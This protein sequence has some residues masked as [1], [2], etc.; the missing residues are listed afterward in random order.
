MKNA[1]TRRVFQNK[2]VIS[3]FANKIGNR[4]LSSF[5]EDK[6]LLN[7]MEDEDKKEAKR[8][9]IFL[10]VSLNI[11]Q[12]MLSVC[13]V[14]YETIATPLTTTYYKVQFYSHL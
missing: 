6:I 12:F 1:M 7:G 9:D 14:V 4:L 11:T 13:F 5:Q 2:L 8:M 3:N 10:I